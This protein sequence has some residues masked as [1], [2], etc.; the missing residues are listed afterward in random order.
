MYDLQ[1]FLKKLDENSV[2]SKLPTRIP[3]K[4]LTIDDL[5]DMAQR[6]GQRIVPSFVLDEYNSFVYRNAILWLM[7]AE[8]FCG[9]KVEG[10]KIVAVAGDPNKGL[11]ISGP[12]GTG[13]TVLTKVLTTLSMAIRL[14]YND[15]NQ[16][17]PPMVRWHEYNCEEAVW[18]YCRCGEVSGIDKPFVL[19]QDLGAESLE[20]VYMGT[21]LNIFRYVIEKR[22]DSGFMGTIFTS[23]LQIDS[24]ELLARYGDR[25][26]S[27]LKGSYNSLVLTGK[28]RRL[29]TAR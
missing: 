11:F 16:I 20:A 28:D 12:T 25:A 13:K 10:N 9:S 29:V 22:S 2:G 27:R 7:G 6:I 23:N 21:R 8:E 14:A 15:P 26:V 18:N 4:G 19:Y 24:Q 3:V 1:K 5:M 17:T